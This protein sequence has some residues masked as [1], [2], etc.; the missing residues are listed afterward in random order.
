VYHP[1]LACG[2]QRGPVL[3][4]FVDKGADTKGCDRHSI[5]IKL[6]IELGPRRQLGI[7]MGPAEEVEGQESLGQQMIP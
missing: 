7:D 5:N 6:V 2:D 1:S 4:L 3:G